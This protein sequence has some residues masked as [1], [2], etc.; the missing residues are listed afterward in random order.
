M[1]AEPANGNNVPV[2]R[3]AAMQIVIFKSE[4]N[5]DLHAFGAKLDGRR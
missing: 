1:L 5:S 3:G 4:A 2:E